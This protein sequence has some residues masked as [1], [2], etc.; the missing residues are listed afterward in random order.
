MSTAMTSDLFVKTFAAH[1][2]LSLARGAQSMRSWRAWASPSRRAWRIASPRPSCS[3]SGVT[4]PIA[5]ER[6]DRVV[7]E[8]CGFPSTCAG[9]MICWGR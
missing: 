2:N 3:S 9:R 5:A 4:Y 8:R 6:P 1:P 7:F